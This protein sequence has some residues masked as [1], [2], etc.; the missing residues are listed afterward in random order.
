VVNLFYCK[1]LTDIS[2]IF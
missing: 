2:K 1:H